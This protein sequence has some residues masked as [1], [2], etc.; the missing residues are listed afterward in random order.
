MKVH[1]FIGKFKNRKEA[2]SYT[3]MYWEPEPDESVSDKE[4][5]LWE[6]NNPKWLMRDELRVN[7]EPDF[8]ETITDD[9][10]QYLKNIL[11]IDTLNAELSFAIQKPQSVLVLIFNKALHKTSKALKSTKTLDYFGEFESIL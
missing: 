10:K 7:L 8:I 3:Q 5:S 11:G 1:V 9:P 4:Y 2:I 6:N